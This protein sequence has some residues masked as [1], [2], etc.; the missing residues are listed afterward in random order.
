MRV[1]VVFRAGLAG[2]VVVTH[3]AVAQS[4]PAHKPK[5]STKTTL[6]VLANE[7]ETA[8][9]RTCEKRFTNFL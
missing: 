2:F 7:E 5:S 9:A 6:K 8:A 3:V 1:S 4:T